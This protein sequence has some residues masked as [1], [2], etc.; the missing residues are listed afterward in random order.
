[1]DEEQYQTMRERACLGKNAYGARTARQVAE[2]ARE[3]GDRVTAYRCPF[4][5]ESEDRPVGHWHVGHPPSL[6]GVVQLAAAIRWRHQ[7]VS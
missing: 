7:H 5:D 3:R 6:E 2:N 1:M 4:G